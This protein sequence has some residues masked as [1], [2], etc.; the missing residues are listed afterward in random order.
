MRAFTASMMLL[1]VTV[2]AIKRNTT[3][4][5]SERGKV[6]IVTAGE[7]MSAACVVPSLQTSWDM[8]E[9]LLESDNATLMKE[10]QKS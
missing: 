8:E 1:R 9:N 10:V 4:G 6:V 2:R 3:S 7:M 5:C